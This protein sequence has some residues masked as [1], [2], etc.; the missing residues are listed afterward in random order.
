V[1]VGFDVSQTA[2]PMAGCAVVA[3]QWMRHLVEVDPSDEFIPYPVFGHY[4]H[5]DFV[6]ATR[7][8]APNV[9][10]DQFRMSWAQLNQAWDRPGSDLHACLGRPDLVH[11][12]NYFCPRGLPVP[13][14]FT[15]YDLSAVERPAWHSERNRLACF[16]GLFDAATYADHL[17]AISAASRDAFRRWF[18][19]VPG[20]R[21]SVVYPA[22]RPSIAVPPPPEAIRAVLRTFDL[23]EDAFWLAVGTIE[24]RKNYAGLLDAYAQLAAESPHTTQP[25][26]IAGQPG[27]IEASLQPRIERLGLGRRVRCL[28]FVPDA[29]LAAL[30]RACFA[31]VY[32]SLYEGFGLPVVEALAC[33]AAVVA[34]RSTS[35]PEVAG[36]SAIL[37]DPTSPAG[38]L[39]AMRTLVS[40]AARRTALRAAA[41]A[42]AARFSW[43]E[44]ARRLIAVY[45]TLH[46]G[47]AR[48]VA[49]IP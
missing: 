49:A 9:L 43:R 8:A 17:V 16:N 1:R 39:D 32:P 42:Q 5:P 25:L 47:H 27:W 19:H 4:R 38:L 45:Q 31:F 48:A 15:L 14:V 35:L 10:A 18:P 7:P 41:P 2:E 30:Y 24:P 44:S 23:E 40:D 37:V 46:V 36:G 34:M 29:D 21:V 28:G 11:A 26:I 12:N 33:G 13:V 6:R 3:D 22:A 20:E